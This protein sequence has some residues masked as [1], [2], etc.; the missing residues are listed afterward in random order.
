[1]MMLPHISISL[2]AGSWIKSFLGDS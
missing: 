2:T 1:M